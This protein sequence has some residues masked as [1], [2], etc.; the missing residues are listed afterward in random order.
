MDE[1]QRFSRGAGAIL[2]GALVLVAVAALLLGHG[3]IVTGVVAGGLVGFANLVLL[4]RMARR[5]M[6]VQVASG[7]LQV[8]AMLRIAVVGGLVA[9]VLIWG[10]VHPV[11]A[12][13]GYGIFPVAASAA[14]LWVLR[15]PVPLAR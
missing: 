10:R 8:A 15:G 13:I 4:V 7:L 9:V 3:E 11:G 5:L 2:V 6:G 1:L 12:V 14:G